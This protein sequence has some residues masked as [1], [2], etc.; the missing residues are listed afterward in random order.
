[1][2]N[3]VFTLILETKFKWKVDGSLPKSYEM[4]NTAFYLLFDYQLIDSN[5]KFGP[6]YNTV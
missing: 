1:M 4:T 3:L 5:L 2:I 6:S